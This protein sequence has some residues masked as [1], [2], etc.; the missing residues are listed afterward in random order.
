MNLRPSK[1][2]FQL[3]VFTLPFVPWSRQESEKP[4]D[5]EP[6]VQIITD[7][8]KVLQVEKSIRDR[9]NKKAKDEAI[10]AKNKTPWER[11]KENDRSTV[12]ELIDILNGK[13]AEKRK[14]VYQGLERN[15][16]DLSSYAITEPE[17]IAL[18]L[19]GVDNPMDE[20]YAVQLAGLNRVLGFDKKFE[21]RL[22]SG[23]STDEGRILFWLGA[24]GKSMKALEYLEAKLK[25]KSLAGKSLDDAITAMK[26][27]G[28]YGNAEMQKK[29]GD[30]AVF[31]Y[32]NKWISR[33]RI[34]ELK[35]YA[36]SS[37]APE[38]L[39]TCLFEYGDQRV[40][41]IAQDILKRN[42]RFFGPITALIRLD[43]PQ[44]LDKVKAMLRDKKTYFQAADVIYE[45]DRKY[46][47]DELLRELL[48][49]FPSGEDMDPGDYAI[50]RVVNELMDLG[51]EDYLKN[52]DKYVSDRAIAGRIAAT[53]KNKSTDLNVVLNDLLTW[54]LI[55]RRPPDSVISIITKES[56]RDPGAFAAGVLD[57]ADVLLSFDME[58]E[59][60]PVD[61]EI[62]LSEFVSNSKG[63]LKDMLIWVDAK[64]NKKADAAQYTIT[65]VSNNKVFIVAPEDL[66]PVYN[67]IAID[68]LMDTVL[69]DL[70]STEKFIP[71][72]PS[73]QMIQYI[74]GDEKTVGALVAKYKM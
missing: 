4:G 13:N 5:P 46:I 71:L 25:A 73:D 34:D 37:E 10:A 47:N 59:S 48:M 74:F 1:T 19:R 22:L 69:A 16:S 56:N 15:Y 38:S 17:L 7:P 30:L 52:I 2:F 62:L 29:V 45:L 41:P 66:G 35:Q 12:P 3:L 72:E 70:Q 31:I 36:H 28:E 42:I 14:A 21:E 58:A 26:Y 32:D 6:K 44:H 39:L 20:P 33:Q 55:D 23:V 24:E 60:F 54:K 43:G 27:F 49:R 67:M 64:P 57:H 65:V 18:I 61:Y 11:Y 40:I 68:K 53:Y 9:L 63:K 8:A 51:A 50:E